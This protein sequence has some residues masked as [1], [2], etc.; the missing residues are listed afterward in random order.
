MGSGLAQLNGLSRWIIVKVAWAKLIAASTFE[1]PDLSHL[2]PHMG[3]W[4]Q[5]SDMKGKAARERGNGPV[6]Q[7]KEN[8]GVDTQKE[9]K[10]PPSFNSVG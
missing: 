4:L 5:R 6:S 8:G 2:F 9:E 3:S 1:L 10:K 7:G